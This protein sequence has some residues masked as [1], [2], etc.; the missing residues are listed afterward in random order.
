MFLRPQLGKA[1]VQEG[2]SAVL[3]TT[4]RVTSQGVGL[5]ELFNSL[6]AFS[7]T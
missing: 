3:R 4:F 5:V 1:L 2:L 7:T 6:L